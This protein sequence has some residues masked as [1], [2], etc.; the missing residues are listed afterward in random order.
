MCPNKN[1]IDPIRNKMTAKAPKNQPM[2]SPATEI[3]AN[4]VT[5]GYIKK[6]KYP[7]KMQKPEIAN[8]RKIARLILLSIK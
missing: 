5:S 7:K 8:P 2:K 1:I 6:N 3:F 4:I